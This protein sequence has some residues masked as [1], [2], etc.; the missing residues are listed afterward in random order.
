MVILYF[1]LIEERKK[2]L[3]LLEKAEK[4][5]HENIWPCLLEGQFMAD[6]LTQIEMKKKLDLEKF[7]IEVNFKSK[8]EYHL[9]NR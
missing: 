7:Q 8:N 5:E 2:I 9:C 4:F 1:F 3:I 6:P